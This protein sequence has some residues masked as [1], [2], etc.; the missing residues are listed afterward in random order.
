MYDDDTEVMFVIGVLEKEVE[1]AKSC[2]QPHDTGHIHTA[3]SWME[4][5]KQ[6]LEETLSN[7]QE[8]EKILSTKNW[9][10]L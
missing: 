9:R 2:L 8:L 3:I 5:R 4:S 1:Y 7:Q 6:E 10:K